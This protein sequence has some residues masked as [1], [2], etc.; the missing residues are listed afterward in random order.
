[1]LRQHGAV[2]KYTAAAMAR[3]V[4]EIHKTDFGIGITGIAGPSGATRAK[5]VGLVY[6]A[7]SVLAET[8]CLQCL[9]KGNRTHIKLQASTQA[10]RLLKK[11]LS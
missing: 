3:A 7:L 9:F 8:L 10:L 2:S 4:R 6:I 11:C 5:P 1:M